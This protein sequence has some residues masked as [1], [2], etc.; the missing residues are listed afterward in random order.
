MNTT[1][2][3]NTVIQVRARA[4]NLAK[5]NFAATAVLSAA[6]MVMAVWSL[7]EARADDPPTPVSDASA[8]VRSIRDQEA[9]VDRV[10]SLSLRAS[11]LYE[12]TPAG[13]SKRRR[14]LQ[15]QLVAEERIEKNRGLRPRAT[16]TIE[17]AFDRKRVR[18]WDRWDPD[19][20][21]LR[22]WDGKRLITYVSYNTP[23]NEREYR[24]GSERGT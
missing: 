14:Q 2:D 6:V 18:W 22:T 16:Q 7:Q 8:L 13:I 19:W 17:L 20:F 12:T 9:W 10:E 15:E 21:D 23:P 1:E 4:M 5:I 3:P 11:V 24:I